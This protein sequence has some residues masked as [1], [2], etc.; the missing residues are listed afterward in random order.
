MNG[1]LVPTSAVF[2]PDG[3]MLVT[4]LYGTVWI[5][6]PLGQP[7]VTR[8]TYLVLQNLNNTAEHG[9]IE[10]VLDPDFAT[11]DY[12]YIYY[13]T[14][15]DKNRVS[16]FV[17]LG[18]SA[19][20]SS[21]TVIFETSDPFT[22]CCHIGGAMAFAND[23]T[24]LLAIG[25]DFIPALAQ[26]LTSSYGKVHRFTRTG[27]VPAD[28]PYFDQTPG[29]FNANGIRKT[30]Y[31]SGLRNPFRGSYNAATNEFLIG[32]VGGN[33]HTVAWEDLHR[34]A[35]AANFGWPFCG[36]G[37]RTTTGQC[38][39]PQYSDPVFT[40]PHAGT[41]ASITAGFTYSGSMFPPVW[42]GRYFYGDYVRGWIRYLQFD[43]LGQVVDDQPFVDP[44]TFGGDTALALVKLLQ[45]PDGALYYITLIDDQVNFTGSVHRIFTLPDQAPVCG[46]VT[47]L[48]ASGP[49]PLLTTMLVASATDA[50]GGALTYNWT[51]GDGSATAYGDTVFHTYSGP[52]TFTAQLVVSDGTTGI[53]CGAVPVT[54]GAPPTAQIVSPAS[55]STFRCGDVITFSGLGT[56]D[57]P[58]SQSS[59]SWNVVFNHDQHIHP[60]TGASG[61]SEFDVVIPTSGHGFSGL[62]YYTITLTVTDADGLTASS[63]VQIFPEKVNVTVNSTPP[64]LEVLVE[65][66]PVI[67]P[68]TVDQA[69][70]Y[71]MQL[72]IVASQQ[73]QNGSSYSFGSWSNGLPMIQPFTVPAGGG[74][75]VA[76]FTQ[77]GACTSCGR[78]LSFDGV[79][80]RVVFTPFTLTGD[81][82]IE[83]WMRPLPGF[84]S[85]D[86]VLG[87]A[88]DLSL[89]L[90]NG[91]L[92]LFKGSDKL[93]SAVDM[94]ANQWN[95]YA[96]TRQGT[97]LALLVNGV[98]DAQAI[99]S[100]LSGGME[101]SWLG[102][103]V[104]VGFLDAALDEVRFWNVVRTPLQVQQTMGSH[105]S[106]SSPGLAAYWR[107]D[108]P[109][110]A[111][112]VD[113]LGPFDRNGVR[114][115]SLMQGTDD[116]VFSATSGPLQFA[117][118]RPVDLGLRMYLQG[119]FNTADQLMR[120]DLRVLGLV[121]LTEPYT[122]LGFDLAGNA[123]ASTQPSVLAVSGPN[124]I[125]DWVLFEVRD[126]LDPTL[127]LS[128][129]AALLQRDGDVVG[130]NG[131]FPLIVQVDRPS[132]YISV[133]HRNHLGAMTAAP[134][135]LQPFDV[136]LDMG[137]STTATYGT[138]ACAEEAGVALLWEGDV[139]RD[140]QLKYTGAANDRDPV[141]QTI[142]GSVPTQVTS[143][144][145]ST[146]VNL[147]GL[148]KYAGVINDRDLILVNIGGLVVTH[149]RHAQL[150]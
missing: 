112:V 19:S 94:E 48:P 18:D 16:R 149:V 27:G 124:A 90:K 78:S 105:V 72:G 35:P 3:R 66:L 122:A 97:A 61:T 69:I 36:D 54:V 135:S 95:H 56:D 79:D 73:C 118:E 136:V 113:D 52:G 119:P 147:D 100:P 80:D 75:V 65:G 74:A 88:T 84:N 101:I 34:S 126:A 87:N 60:E 129:Q 47:A 23:S 85:S 4:S 22:N 32:E 99:T 117:C 91:K 107:F 14:T 7:P 81:W 44:A 20:L 123:G 8:T 110:N 98:V 102:K 59:Y 142:G 77:T 50:E 68:Y 93:V 125:V 116:P 9:L 76:Q 28:N 33:D 53:S 15:S 26:D 41:G 70:G 13:S 25:D 1:L 96:I 150:P 2:L 130:T 49:G 45:G 131:Q 108:Q 17:H 39:D 21:E 83:F 11:N 86:A 106:P 63:S 144:Y 67:T 37:G 121:P 111:Q 71:Q 10:I 6:S 109:S 138:E 148:T 62:T 55:G 133:R 103:G 137:A 141:L 64:G 5:T 38:S 82:T 43:T 57:G 89:D 24:M 42:Q 145:A 128:R 140:G 92:R 12:F 120:D 31:A 51:F 127:V 139:N 132:A 30:I 104:N 146:D 134:I 58:L 115:S 143:G 40:Y 114:G 29:L 46:T